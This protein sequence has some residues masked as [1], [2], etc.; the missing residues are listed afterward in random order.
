MA[1][2]I[3]EEDE[4]GKYFSGAPVES[5]D[6]VAEGDGEW[7][8]YFSNDFSLTESNGEQDWSAYFPD[9]NKQGP[10]TYTSDLEFSSASFKQRQGRGFGEMADYLKRKTGLESPAFITNYFQQLEETGDAEVKGYVPDYPSN[11]LE[12]DSTVGWMGEKVKQQAHEQAVIYG[13]SY[14]SQLLMRSGHP[15]LATIGGGATVAITFNAIWDE[16]MQELAHLNG[17]QVGDLTDAERDTAFTLAIQNTALEFAPT[18]LASKGKGAFKSAAKSVD[19]FATDMSKWLKNVDKDS[20]LKQGKKFLKSSLG[21]GVKEATTEA[22]A[23]ANTMRVS[24]PGL[25]FSKTDEGFGQLVSSAAGGLA[26]G[27]VFGSP[28]SISNSREFNKTISEGT[29]FL[30]GVNTQ[31]R[32]KSAEEYVKEINAGTNLAG[33]D[34][35]PELYDVPTQ[36]KGTAKRFMDLLVEKGL[37]R[38]TT[39]FRNALNKTKTGRDVYDLHTEVFGSLAGTE[40]FSG[41]IQGKPSFN[42]LKN[43]KLNEYSTRFFELQSKWS[44]KIPLAGEMGEKINPIIDAYVGASLENRLTDD[45]S[46]DARKLL[47]KK[48]L[49]ELDKD[50]KELRGI[51]DKVYKDLKTVLK[52]SDISLGYT[53]NYL[54]RGINYNAAKKNKEGFINSLVDDVGIDPAKVDDIYNDILNG[55]DPSTLSSKQIKEDKERSGTGKSS[56]EKSRS[57]NWDNLDSAFRDNS[58]FNSMQNY[59][60]RAATR[61]ASAETFGGRNA[62]KFT[63]SIDR[64]LKRG[65]LTNQGAQTA[66]DMYDAEHN[67]YKKPENEQER[68]WQ[69][70]S[71]GLSTV[72]AISLLGLAS[73]AS[74]TE[75]M[76]IPGRVGFANTV[77]ALPTVAGYVLK[78]MKRTVYG[79]R[80]GKEVDKSFGRQLL[81]TMGMAINPQVNE[82]IEMMMAGD[83]NPALT[84]WFRTP[85]GLFLTQYTNFV[86]T[87]TAAAGLKMIQD[88]A[89]QVNRLKGGKLAGLTRELRENG[90][91]VNDFKQVVRLGNGKID[92]LN[93]E[94]LN[95]RY[96]KDN[97]T[98]IS[99]RDS[100]VPWLR[101]ITTDV[102]LEPNVGNRPLWMS[103]PNLQLLAQLKSF[104]I[105]FSNTVM[106]RTLKQLNPNECTPGITGAV[107]ALGATAMALAMAAL[108]IEIKSSI[109]GTDKDVGVLDVIGAMG[110][111]YVTTDR[112]SQ[113]AIPAGMSVLDGFSSSFLKI[114]DGEGGETM[115]DLQKFL[116]KIVA[117]TVVSEQVGR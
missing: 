103:N 98:S 35:L 43:D 65:V 111:P 115:E 114:F 96:T 57:E 72:T 48:R 81:N 16:A 36:E 60:V 67:I 94:F 73:V 13:G 31:N 25:A 91:T 46:Y 102:A 74:L 40:S 21:V 84:T 28:Q 1:K 112:P 22:A 66:W 104:P 83:Y 24:D 42:Q 101:K 50:I 80:V 37:G 87:W 2:I 93:D 27:P 3:E 10:S 18:K 100:I 19:G 79:G 49:A 11:V 53:E 88:Q 110:I 99:V 14:V 97:G 90:M 82:K 23:Q 89:K 95:K 113:L 71:K 63:K 12:A 61:S 44:R 117:G 55:K 69:D 76:W 68:L 77:K 30:E 6:T 52:D 108:V 47:G 33:F 51:H 34:T 109:R 8:K 92:I 106:K 7:S 75:P 45:E 85:G 105:L 59:L 116:L 54:T 9:A 107:Q 15:L 70:F 20:I 78:G 26:G 5:E 29:R 56:F 62:E 64:L 4:W 38:S 41:D 58:A 32:F 39:E 17:K 86:R